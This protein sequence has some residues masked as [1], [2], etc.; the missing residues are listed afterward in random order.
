MKKSQHFMLR[1]M[2][3]IQHIPEEL[4]EHG[5]TAAGSIEGERVWAKCVDVK[6][7]VSG[8]FDSSRVD[9]DEKFLWAVMSVDEL[10]ELELTLS[11]RLVIDFTKKLEV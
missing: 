4:L 5:D 2:S 8:G 1:E 9:P 7:A 10:T 11:E 3:D 6:R